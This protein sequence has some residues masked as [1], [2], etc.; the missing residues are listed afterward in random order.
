MDNKTNDV[1][2]K[3]DKILT[4][5][6]SACAILFILLV[7]KWIITIV[8]EMVIYVVDFVSDFVS[9]TDKVIIV[10]MI[11]G[12]VSIFG[13]VISSIISKIVEYRYNVKR[14]LYDKKENAYQQYIEMVFRILL[15]SKKAPEDKMTEKEIVEVMSDLSK[16]LA[17]WGSNE[18][19]KKYLDF[20]KSSLHYEPSN[21]YDIIFKVEDIIFEIRKDMGMKKKLKR[22]EILS[23]FIND[24]DVEQDKSKKQNS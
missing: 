17:L 10:A 13:V 18:V 1:K 20:R 8:G 15:D 14:Y 4:W 11:S 19:V 7:V 3:P 12:A 22:G 24:V 5:L 2:K 9:S 16:S 21:N 6:I 23:L